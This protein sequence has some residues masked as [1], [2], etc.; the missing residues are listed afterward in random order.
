MNDRQRVEAILFPVFFQNVLK[1]G[2]NDK[3]S[4]DYKACMLQLQQAIDIALTGCD[5]RRR[6]SLMRRTIRLHN[7][8]TE[9]H[10]RDYVRVEKMG[11]IALYT[12]QMVLD[13]DYLVLVEGSD[14]SEAINAI[15]RGL[16][17]AFSEERLDASA[18]KQAGRMLSHLQQ[19]GYFDG[20]KREA[21]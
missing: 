17:D 14:L 18:Q 4:D 10:R 20:V 5:E 15:V 21:A 6:D 3:G 12:L 16:A 19:L 2:V 7:E 11:L 8:I 9:S 1:C 13:A